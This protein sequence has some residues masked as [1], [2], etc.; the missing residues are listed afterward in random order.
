MTASYHKTYMAA[1]IKITRWVT[2]TS[3]DQCRDK[4]FKRWWMT[5]EWLGC[6]GVTKAAICWSSLVILSMNRLG[7]NNGYPTVHWPPWCFLVRD[8]AALVNT[9][10]FNRWTVDSPTTHASSPINNRHWVCP[11]TSS[12]WVNY[13]LAYTTAPIIGF[14][15]TSGHHGVK[16]STDNGYMVSG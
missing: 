11:I 16:K 3:K 7:A 9:P 1:K 5:S 13:E 15:N 6:G 14:P 12:L 10:A 8:G 4:M 2:P